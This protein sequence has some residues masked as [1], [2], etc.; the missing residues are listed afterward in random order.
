MKPSNTQALIS[1]GWLAPLR[2]KV[3]RTLWLTWLTASICMW[4]NDVAAAWT[5]AGL[6]TSATLI[7]LVQTA[8]SLPV[9]LLGVPSGALADILNR[10]HYFVFAQIWL[11]TNATALM[12]TLVFGMLNPYLLLFLTFTNGIGLAMRWPIFAAIVPEIVPE[13]DWHESRN[14]AISDV[15]RSIHDANT[16]LYPCGR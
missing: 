5:M 4:M 3:F 13:S 10:K 16:P 15:D 9:L 1:E 7:A 6:T 11:A 14:A 2:H 12:F 8:A